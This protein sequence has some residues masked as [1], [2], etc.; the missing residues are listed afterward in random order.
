M[1]MGCEAL[2]HLLNASEHAFCQGTT[3]GLVAHVR[4]CPNCQRGIELFSFA[5]IAQNV[6]TCE[7]CRTRF[8]H[9]Y[10]ATRSEYSLVEMA[11][12]EIAEVAIHLGQCV[13][14]HAEYEELVLLWEL[15]ERNEMV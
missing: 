1:S 3:P 9:Y 13:D 5:F 4:S 8:P 11:E 14:C 7:Q 6:L 10:E 2:L 15:E 12:I